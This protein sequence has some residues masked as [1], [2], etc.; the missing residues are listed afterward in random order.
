[1]VKHID[2]ESRRRAVLAATINMYIEEAEPVSSEDIARDFALSSATIRNIFAELEEIGYI[3]H[4]HTSGGRI[5][6]NKGYR[7]YVDFLILQMELLGAEKKRISNEYKKA[8]RRIEDALE[9]TSQIL[10]D[11]THYAGMVSLLDW[12]SRLYY[13]GISNILDQPEFRNIDKMRIL[14][15]MLEEKQNLLDI[16]NRDFTGSVR[17]YIGN[18]LD[19]PGME[20]CS[21]VVSGYSFK[22]KPLGRVAVLGPARMEYKHTISALAYVSEVLTGVLDN[23]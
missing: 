19:Y 6:T 14:I 17:V 1:M 20:N 16:I 10:S 23:I 9:Q 21:L 22:D 18:E 3:T 8:V 7:Y 13:R 11:V 4:P 12:R 15:N 2:Y 5:P